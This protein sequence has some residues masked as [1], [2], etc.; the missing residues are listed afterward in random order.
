MCSKPRK[1]KWS[2][3]TTITA[4]MFDGTSIIE[5]MTEAQI[6]AGLLTLDPSHEFVKAMFALLDDGIITEQDAVTAPNLTDAA[7]HFN[8]G[9]LAHA[10]DVRGLVADTMR[11]AARE[12]AEA[13]AKKQRAAERES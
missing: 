9:R 6:K 5:F 12:R 13:E 10:K 7:R 1:K 8:A 2:G 4:G 3:Y 11:D